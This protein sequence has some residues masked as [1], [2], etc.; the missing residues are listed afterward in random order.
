MKKNAI[1]EIEEIVGRRIIRKKKEYRV[2]WV[3]Y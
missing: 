2:K 1:Y 3:G